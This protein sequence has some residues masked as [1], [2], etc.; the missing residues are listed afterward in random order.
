MLRVNASLHLK[1][2]V[3]TPAKRTKVLD[4]PA[5]SILGNLLVALYAQLK[6]GTTLDQWKDRNATLRFS[7]P[8]AFQF[9]A[10]GGLNDATLGLVVGRGA[11]PVTLADY[12]L[13]TQCTHGIGANQLQHQATTWLMGTHTAASWREFIQRAFVNNSGSTI[14]VTESGLYC[15]IYDGS[16]NGFLACI[17]RDV[18]TAITVP[19]AKT[20]TMEY[21]LEVPLL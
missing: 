9:Y 12:K 8:S 6:G 14:S 15:N 1:A 4:Q 5:H 10:V 21:T 20:L 16:A 3:G 2:W 11:T 18:F 7:G 19:N 17:I 13:E